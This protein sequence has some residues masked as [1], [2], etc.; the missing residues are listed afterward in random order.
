MS[1]RTEGI[2][3]WKHGHSN[4]V[5]MIVKDKHEAMMLLR[6]NKSIINMMLNL[7]EAVKL[8]KLK[9]VQS[10][11]QQSQ[12]LKLSNSRTH[13]SQNS[14]HKPTFKSKMSEN[15]NQS[16]STSIDTGRPTQHNQYNIQV[17]TILE[18]KQSSH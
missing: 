6:H 11:L 8:K 1:S 3:N 5:H 15:K 4:M 16:K 14:S 12:K 7:P 13:G 17:S 18:E 10:C 9:K 2:R